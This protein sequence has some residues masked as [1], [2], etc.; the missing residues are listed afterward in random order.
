MA[1]PGRQTAWSEGAAGGQRRAAGSGTSDGEPRRLSARVTSVQFCVPLTCARGHLQA[2]E[3]AGYTELQ[4]S[5][6]E[7]VDEERLNRGG[8]EEKIPG[9]LGRRMGDKRHDLGWVLG[10]GAPRRDPP[11][12]YKRGVGDCLD[13]LLAYSPQNFFPLPLPSLCLSRGGLQGLS[14]TS[15]LLSS[16]IYAAEWNDLP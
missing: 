3:Q 16:L 10:A 9:S 7:R 8:E 5:H 6:K 11:P 14:L 12:G 4:C 13:Q 2:P 15:I 1:R